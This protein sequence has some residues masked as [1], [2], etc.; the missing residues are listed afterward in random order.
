MADQRD[1]LKELFTAIDAMDTPAFLSKLAP[2][3][4]FR[5]G[6]S[7]EVQGHNAIGAAVDGFFSSIAAVSHEI[8]SQIGAGAVLACEGEV[9]YTRHDATTITLPFAN[10]FEFD[11]PLISGYRIYIEI[12][13]LYAT[14]A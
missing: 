13:P 1:L 5:F 2:E 6:A 3:A 4:V 10:V 7:P 9:T 12:A 11:G 8:T 14:T